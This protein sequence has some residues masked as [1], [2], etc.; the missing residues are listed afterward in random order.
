MKKN[1]LFFAFS[2]LVLSS[3]N[4][5]IVESVPEQ[6]TLSGNMTSVT[7]DVDQ[8]SLALKEMPL[9]PNEVLIPYTD[10]P[11]YFSSDGYLVDYNENARLAM[12]GP[13]TVPAG[14]GTLTKL[15]TEKILISSSKVDNTYITGVYICD[16][17]QYTYTVNIP[18]GAVVKAELPNPCGYSNYYNQTKGASTELI[19]DNK[20]NSVVVLKYYSLVPNYNTAGQAVGGP[21][22]P[23]DLRK[24]TFVYYIIK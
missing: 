22:L 11:L 5:D 1:I 3:C 17:Y 12:E 21:V 19:T 7:I 24:T 13:Y 20:G 10:K 16:V 8:D 18:Y 2:L 9:S 14:K 4:S 15:G 23:I 6:L